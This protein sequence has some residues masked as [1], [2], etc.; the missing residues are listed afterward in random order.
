MKLSGLDYSSPRRF[1]PKCNK[2]KRLI[3]KGVP[4]EWRG[5]CWLFYSGAYDLSMRNAEVY[6]QLVERV[7]QG[8]LKTIGNDADL[9]ERD[10]YRTFPDN[11]HYNPN[12]RDTGLNN[13]NNNNHPVESAFERRGEDTNPCVALP[14]LTQE[15]LLIQRLRRLL[16]CFSLHSPSIGYCQSLNFIAALLLLFMN[17][18][19]AFWMLNIITTRIVPNVHNRNLSGLT[20]D[21][22]VLLLCV[23]R[24]LPDVYPLLSGGNAPTDSTISNAHAPS[25]PGTATTVGAG[26]AVGSG[27][28]AATPWF[29][30][31]FITSLPLETTLRIWDCLFYN[32]S[33]TLFR[34]SLQIINRA[35]KEKEFPLNLHPYDIDPNTLLNH[36]KGVSQRDIDTSRI[37]VERKRSLSTSTT[38]KAGGATTKGALAISLW[39]KHLKRK[40]KGKAQNTQ[41]TTHT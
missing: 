19:H 23:K 3:Q 40:Q 30:T 38:N 34:V 13:N 10:L 16:L 11:I 25:S 8:D 21:L 17:E 14:P 15:P 31:L 37:Y 7:T 12:T 18:E 27:V 5:N 29:M 20:T 41:P 32:G 1:P 4:P 6:P 26:V 24:Y 33:K 2:V 22:E 9:I 28:L 36:F 35:S 39:N